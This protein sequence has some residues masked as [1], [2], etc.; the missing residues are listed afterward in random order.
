MGAES[1]ALRA[2]A[3]RE[4]PVVDSGGK[5]YPAKPYENVS[6]ESAC[7]LRPM[8]V[9]SRWM[10]SPFYQLHYEAIAPKP[11]LHARQS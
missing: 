5:D 4:K 6:F 2:K 9:P 11:E 3:R 8:F 7:L 10:G 1:V